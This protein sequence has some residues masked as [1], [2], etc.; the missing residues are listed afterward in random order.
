M[1]RMHLD[2]SSADVKEKKYKKSIEK[3]SN[4]IEKNI[5]KYN[6]YE[7]SYKNKPVVAYVMLRSME[8]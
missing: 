3:L 8:G 5:K 1:T 7:P 2:K 4:K 6:E